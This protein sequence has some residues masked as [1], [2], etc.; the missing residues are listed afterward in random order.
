[1]NSPY[2]I[3]SQQNRFYERRT[4]NE[5]TTLIIGF[6]QFQIEIPSMRMRGTF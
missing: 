2:D 1:M 5:A 6:L 4:N 3:F